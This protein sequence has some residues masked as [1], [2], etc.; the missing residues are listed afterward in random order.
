MHR[1]L[2]RFAFVLALLLALPVRAQV[3][4]QQ[5]PDADPSGTSA[6]IS[7][8]LDGA[9]QSPGRTAADDFTLPSTALIRTVNWWGVP[10]SGGYDFTFTFYTNAG[11]RPGSILHTTQGSLSVTTFNDFAMAYT[12][13][14]D[15]PFLAQAGTKY[16]ISVFNQAPDASWAWQAQRDPGNLARQGPNPGPPWPTLWENL[17]FRFTPE[18]TSLWMLGA[19][20]AIIGLRPQ[21]ETSAPQRTGRAERSL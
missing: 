10:N 7:S 21:R 13:N 1:H 4:Y 19:S 11:N 20:L 14:L 18:P 2:L 9:G 12:S 8:M 16:W 17:T 3:I 15:S 5:L 6:A